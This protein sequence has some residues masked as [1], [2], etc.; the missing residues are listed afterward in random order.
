M[1]RLWK[2]LLV[3]GLIACCCSGLLAQS[4]KPED[5]REAKTK[6]EKE[7]LPKLPDKGQ[8]P[9]TPKK[10]GKPADGEI[11]FGAKQRNYRKQIQAIRHKHFGKMRVAKVRQQGIDQILEFT[12]PAAYEPLIN[13]LV[14]EADDVRLAL[15]DHFSQQGDD[16]QGALAWIAVYEKDPAIRNESMM[17]LVSP[18][19]GPVLNVLDQA[20]R[21]RNDHI[22]TNAGAL[23]GALNALET[24]PLLIFAQA[25]S[26]PVNSRGDLAWMAIETQIAFTQGLEP[27]VGDGSAGFRPIIGVISDGFVLRIV[28]AVAISYRTQIHISLVAMTT[29][30]WGQSTEY[31]GYDMGQWREWYNTE[32]IPFKNE[33]A[34]LAKLA[35]DS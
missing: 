15:L 3:I 12:D 7:Q 32:Y 23:A 35:E 1:L 13:E 4:T 20:L 30:D 19:T 5:Q 22:A 26:S 27:V 6:A 14:K 33:Q 9:P 24:I 34:E 25:A 18:A 29:H 8:I 28:D 2:K 16:G 21:S 31:L 17:R 11:A 10:A